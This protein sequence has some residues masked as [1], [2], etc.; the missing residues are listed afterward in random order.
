MTTSVRSTK[1]ETVTAVVG[2]K[3]SGKVAL[4]TGGTR[5][6]GAAI[7]SSLAIQGA[8]IAAGYSGNITRAERFK[9]E[10]A[11]QFHTPVTVHQ[12]R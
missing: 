6:I 2:D 11:D 12:G 10:S 8:A 4:V 7:S 3:L 9:E 1:S 5:G